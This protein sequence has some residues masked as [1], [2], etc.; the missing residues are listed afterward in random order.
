V[1]RTIQELRRQ[2]LV[3]LDRQLLTIPDMLALQGVALFNPEYLHL[4][5]LSRHTHDHRE[6]QTRLDGTVG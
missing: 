3:I 6:A 4:R 1:N 2:G 5:R